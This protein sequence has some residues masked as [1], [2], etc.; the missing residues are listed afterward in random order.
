MSNRRV[1]IAAVFQL[2]RL[3]VVLAL[4]LAV[5]SQAVS[6]VMAGLCMANDHHGGAVQSHDGDHEHD[7]HHDVPAPADHQHEGEG[8]HAS[9]NHCPPGSTAAV[10]S[11][12]GVLVLPEGAAAGPIAAVSRSV[13][14]IQPDRLDRPPLAL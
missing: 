8:S 2:G 4:A 7:H 14:G 10:I 6:A 12:A 11:G 5:P 9:G 13:A 3:L 1:T